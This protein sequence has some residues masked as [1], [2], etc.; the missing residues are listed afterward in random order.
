MHTRATSCRKALWALGLLVLIA[1]GS[2]AHHH[3]AFAAD[4]PANCPACELQ[5]TTPVAPTVPAPVAAPPPVDY[6]PPQ[7]LAAPGPRPRQPLAEAPKTSP[8]A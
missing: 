8:P 3:N 1:S 4:G 6:T 2:V 7:V 5:Q